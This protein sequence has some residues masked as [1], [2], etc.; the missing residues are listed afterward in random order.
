MC[1][2]A[3]TYMVVML[4]NVNLR[5]C[6]GMTIYPH[7]WNVNLCSRSGIGHH[8][9]VH[10]TRTSMKDWVSWR[11]RTGR[12]VGWTFAIYVFSG[13][14]RRN[15]HWMQP[16]TGNSEKK[17]KEVVH[18]RSQESKRRK[19]M[20][21][22]VKSTYWRVFTSQVLFFWLQLLKPAVPISWHLHRAPHPHVQC[23]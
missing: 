6:L 21:S 23:T 7:T 14:K 15:E 3:H 17:S 4:R 19:R 12:T 8:W 22:K 18:C 10:Y 5:S 9:N 13:V 11:W 20:G 2:C 16:T 1:V